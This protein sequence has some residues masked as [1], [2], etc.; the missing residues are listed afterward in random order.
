[1]AGTGLRWIKDNDFDPRYQFWTRANV[2]EVLPDPPSPLGW[3]LV[4]EGAAVDG[5]RDLFIHRCGMG[6]DELSVERCEAIG[7]FGGYAYLGAALFRIWAGRTPG[8]TASTIDDVY[9]GDHP[10]V[11]PYVQEP[12]HLRESTTAKMGEYMVW[13]TGPMNQDELEADREDSLRIM[14][15]RPDFSAMADAEVLGYAV[16]L[17][18]TLRRMFDQHINQSL[19]ASIGPGVLGQICAAVGRPN[20]AS[21]MM[22]GFGTVDS[23]LPSYAMWDLSR[24]ARASAEI[25]A[26]FAIGPNG[27]DQRL[28]A[29]PHTDVA[30]F[31][32]R[33]DEFLAEFGSRGFNEWDLAA[34]TWEVTPDAALAAIDRMRLAEDSA[35]PKN[36]N[37]LR[38]SERLQVAGEIRE[39]IAADPEALGAFE[40]GLRSAATFTPGRERSKTTI[41]RVVH[42]C[43]MA[44]LELGSRAV[45]RGDLA[46]RDDIF[47]LFVDEVEALVGGKL[48]NAKELVGPRWEYRRHLQSLEPPFIITGPPKSNTTWPRRD[49]ASHTALGVGESLQGGVGCPGVATGR[50][51]VVLDPSDPTALEPGDILVAPMTDPSWTPLFVT[52]AAVVVDVGAQL[53]HAMIVSREL[54][55]PCVPSALNATKRIPDG[56]LVKVD[57]T[58]GTVT[59]LELP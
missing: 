43:R 14:A 42:E 36:E 59:V 53:S 16:G 1:M 5:W 17:R 13:A 56:A 44:M 34:P 39:M 49:A 3:D 9:F 18:P 28:R 22:V 30:A 47:M 45:G 58:A 57:G 35:S 19:S 54:G 12:W 27:L 23:A 33:F 41:I 8:M 21:R 24:L 48:P 25:N 10:D 38:E 6:E 31:V 40:M 15:E 2:S 46:A 50:A 51:R 29:S 26:L 55:I 7:I 37:A 52:A 4:W 11:P 32:T 20:D